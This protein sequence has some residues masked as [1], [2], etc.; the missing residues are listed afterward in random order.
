MSGEF[1]FVFD[2]WFLMSFPF[3]SVLSD[4]CPIVLTQIAGTDL[5]A[6]E[7][8]DIVYSIVS[9]CTVGHA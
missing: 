7:V 8:L 6:S 4:L 9:Y 5:R 3:L 1:A 2:I